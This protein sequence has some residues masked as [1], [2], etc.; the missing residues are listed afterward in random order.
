LCV[1]YVTYS[2]TK[3]TNMRSFLL[4]VLCL[5]TIG[6]EAWDNNN[7]QPFVY[8]DYKP[9]K[10]EGCYDWIEFV[11]DERDTFNADYMD[12]WQSDCLDGEIDTC[13]EAAIIWSWE[14]YG[15]GANNV[16][17]VDVEGFCNTPEE[18]GWSYYCCDFC[19]QGYKNSDF[20]C[21]GMQP[22]LVSGCT[23]PSAS[24]YDSTATEN[25]GSCTYPEP[26]PEAEPEPEPEQ[27]AVCSETC[28]EYMAHYNCDQMRT[29][30][31]DC[32]PCG[33]D[34]KC[35]ETCKEYLGQGQ[36][37]EAMASYGIDC[38]ACDCSPKCSASCKQ[39]LENFSCESL[40]Q[41]H[42]L[43]CSACDCT[44]KCFDTCK[45]YLSQGL[46]CNALM[47]SGIDCSACDKCSCTQC[48]P[49]LSNYSCEQLE[50][51]YQ[52]DCGDCV[53]CV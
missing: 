36:T 15:C 43:D 1:A 31:F 38:S 27:P 21:G 34:T 47:N 2:F 35:T 8:V 4:L 28:K 20:K 16:E 37:C 3:S 41:T 29:F 49:Y 39:A 40:L 48:G 51:T 50:S 32:T 44:P 42:G 53:Q 52:M 9:P 14:C 13:W 11:I 10:M 33:C 17:Y 7:R 24:N 30:G 26:E 45:T 25:D 19:K 46:T 12:P 18:H 5:L 22:K 23:D 6:I